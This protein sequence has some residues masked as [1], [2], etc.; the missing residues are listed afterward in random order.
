MSVW[1]LLLAAF[2]CAPVQNAAK[3]TTFACVAAFNREIADRYPDKDRCDEAAETWKRGA[4]P[5]LLLMHTASCVP[6]PV[7]PDPKK[8]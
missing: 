7:P 3:E 2:T 5:D 6:V 1:I 4:R 8:K